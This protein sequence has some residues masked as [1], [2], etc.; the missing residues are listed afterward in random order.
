MPL[1]GARGPGRARLPVDARRAAG[2][3]LGRRRADPSRRVQQLPRLDRQPDRKQLSLRLFQS[4]S[5]PDLL[6]ESR[7]HL[8]VPFSP[9]A[10]PLPFFAGSTRR[11]PQDRPGYRQAERRRVAPDAAPAEPGTD[12]LGAGRTHSLDG[13]PRLGVGAGQQPPAN[14]C[15]LRLAGTANTKID[16]TVVADDPDGDPV[17]G[18]IQGY[19]REGL[20]NRSG[21][22]RLLVRHV[23]L[24]RWRAAAHRDPLRRLDQHHDPFRHC[25]DRPLSVTADRSPAGETSPNSSRSAGHRSR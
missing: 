8:H 11:R 13:E 25:P 12:E 20:I 22:L 24:A 19:G 7:R 18:V 17:L 15:R 9:D 10:N 2:T 5:D 14:A 21:I 23:I 6:R 3:D 4:R 1:V 16:F